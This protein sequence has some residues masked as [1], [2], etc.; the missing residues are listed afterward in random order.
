MV[1]QGQRHAAA[2]DRRTH[3]RLPDS[4]V[5]FGRQYLGDEVQAGGRITFGAWLN[6]EHN[7]GAAGRFYAT[8]GATDRFAA[9]DVPILAR[10]FFN[11]LLDRTTC[12]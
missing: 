9:D 4:E 8:G 1:D 3:G 12:S 6:D 10:P 7:V 11:V 2:G 5:L